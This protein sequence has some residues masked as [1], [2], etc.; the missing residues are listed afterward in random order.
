MGVAV[1]AVVSSHALAIVIGAVVIAAVAVSVLA[2]HLHPGVTPTTATATGVATGLTGTAA[3]IEGPPLPTT[4]YIAM[5]LGI[6]F[7]LLVG[8]G[9]MALVFYSSRHGYDA[10]PQYDSRDC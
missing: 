2:A 7:S 6:V 5:G 3:A 9:L 4:G 8:C 1:V 10:P